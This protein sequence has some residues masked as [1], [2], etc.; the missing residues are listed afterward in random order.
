VWEAEKRGEVIA[1]RDSE[2]VPIPQCCV[3]TA[4]C[5]VMQILKNSI[6]GDAG[7]ALSGLY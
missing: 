5:S 7:G 6:D 1:K 3:S 4:P 2:V